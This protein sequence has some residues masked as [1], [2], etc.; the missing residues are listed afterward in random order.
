MIFT[1]KNLQLV[2][3]SLDLAIAELHNQIATCPDV[4]EFADDIAEYERE[5]MRIGALRE[6]VDRAITREASKRT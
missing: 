6:R 2:R 5:K 1:G 4:R 3:D